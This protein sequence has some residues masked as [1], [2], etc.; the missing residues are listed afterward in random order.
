MDQRDLFFPYDLLFVALDAACPQ[1]RARL[2]ELRSKGALEEKTR[3]FSVDSHC[4]LEI[5]MRDTEQ[6]VETLSSSWNKEILHVFFSFH[7]HMWVAY[8]DEEAE[9][10]HFG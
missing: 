1:G 4:Y 7:H 6:G 5:I 9:N 10:T 2:D 8:I 3:L